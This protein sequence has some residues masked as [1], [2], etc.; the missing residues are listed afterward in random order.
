MKQNMHD[1][2]NDVKI[3]GIERS[4]EYVYINIFTDKQLYVVCFMMQYILYGYS[5]NPTLTQPRSFKILVGG[6]IEFFVRLF[7]LLL[8]TT[9]KVSKL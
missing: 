6:I 7:F 5:T 9:C 4:D 3:Y 8:R 1:H 2:K